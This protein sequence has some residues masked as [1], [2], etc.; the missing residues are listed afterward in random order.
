MKSTEAKALTT[1]AGGLFNELKPEVLK[2]IYERILPYDKI[3]V[4]TA[5]KNHRV[6]H[7]FFNF[8][9]FVEGCRAE[10]NRSQDRL[11]RYENETVASWLTRGRPSAD[12]GAAITRHFS[13]AWAQ[14]AADEKAD[15][16]GKQTTRRM[17][18]GHA[19]N[20]LREIGWPE[21]DCRDSAAACVGLEP[22]Q[23]INVPSL[24]AGHAFDVPA[25]A[26]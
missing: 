11:K 12:K 5:M 17:L 16:Y 6:N 15:D 3:S 19:L 2:L 4:E 22:G 8:P 24:K 9:Q 7:E 26:K 1:K 21:H 14:V 13:D 20:A 18:H 25:G 10:R 23:T